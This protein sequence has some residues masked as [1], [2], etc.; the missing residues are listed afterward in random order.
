MATNP[1][2]TRL[3]DISF[4]FGAKISRI[5]LSDMIHKKIPLSGVCAYF[6]AYGIA[7]AVNNA[8]ANDSL[9]CLA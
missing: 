9:L 1:H 8:F 2:V 6:G 5:G 3:R 4:G 7:T